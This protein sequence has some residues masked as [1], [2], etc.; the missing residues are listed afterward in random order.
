MKKLLVILLALAMLFSFAACG[1]TEPEGNG[2][3]DV[4]ATLTPT[5]E[6]TPEPV[7]GKTITFEK[8]TFVVPEG[9]TESEVGGIKVIY[10]DDFPNVADSITL[11]KTAADSISNYSKDMFETQYAQSVA[12]F[13]GV[14][15]FEKIEIDGVDSLKIGIKLETSGVKLT[16]TQYFMFFSDMTVVIGFAEVEGTPNSAELADIVKTIQVV[17]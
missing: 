12:G 17:K 5:A 15:S 8:V 16:Q 9:Y 14:E 7:S 1:T 6:P 4:E 2:G 10:T 13:T 3:T 11:T